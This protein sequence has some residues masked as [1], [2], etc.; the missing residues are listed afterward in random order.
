MIRYRKTLDHKTSCTMSHFCLTIKIDL[1]GSIFNLFIC[2]HA[3][4]NRK[5]PLN[6]CCISNCPDLPTVEKYC[7]IIKQKALKNGGNVRGLAT[8]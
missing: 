1:I 5:Y 8:M 3:A 2:L 7:T 6:R 4:L